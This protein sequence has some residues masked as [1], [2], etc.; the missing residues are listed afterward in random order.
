M[1]QPSVAVYGAAGDD[2]GQSVSQPSN[3]VYGAAG[4]DCG[5]AL[6]R[7]WDPVYGA[8]GGGHRSVPRLC[9]AVY[10]LAL[11]GTGQSVSQ[12]SGPV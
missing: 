1:S 2:C 4:D 11:G 12:P 9:V 8:A 10:G 5:E 3:S 7:L 6:A